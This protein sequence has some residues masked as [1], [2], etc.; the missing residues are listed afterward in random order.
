MRS[1]PSLAAVGAVLVGLS[2]PAG[3]AHA[4]PAG[5][6]VT[7]KVL[8]RTTLGDTDYILREVTIPPGQTTGWH[9][10]N[11]P[12]RGYVARGT[13]HHYDATCASD[14]VYTEG[15]PLREAAGPGYVHLGR[16]PGATDLVLRAVYALPHGAP[17]SQD[18]P[19]P[20][21]DFE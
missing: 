2:L 16:N 17:F 19:N 11:G 12:V 4:T 10:H 15:D 13:L 8:A 6:G 5:P 20:G 9:Y 7:G 14:G 21:C 1:L 3:A 18:A